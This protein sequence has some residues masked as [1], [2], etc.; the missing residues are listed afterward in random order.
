M[1]SHGVTRGHMGRMGS[2]GGHVG[3]TWGSREI[4]WGRVGSRG[5]AWGHLREL[6]EH[7]D[8]VALGE[9]V[10]DGDRLGT[11]RR[12]RGA[13]LHGARGWGRRGVSGS[14]TGCVCVV[15]TG[16]EGRAGRVCVVASGCLC[17]G[18]R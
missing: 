17:G 9:H 16:R 13:R 11:H 15:D 12:R 4:T 3:A 18:Y 10:H 5:V 6:V 8:K 7:R 14:L 1:G 2:H